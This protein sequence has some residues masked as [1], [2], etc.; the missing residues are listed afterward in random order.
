[1]AS[2]NAE[3]VAT[4]V[5]E[6]IRR[7]GRVNLGEIIHQNGYSKETS[8]KPKL[9]TTTKSYKAIMK[10]LAERMKSEID[11]ITNALANKDLDK[12]EYKTLSDA[13]EKQYKIYQ[14]ATGGVTEN[15]KITIEVSEA[16]AKK[17]ATNT[18]TE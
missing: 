8:L 6:T 9:V 7:G 11:R 2:L 4:I 13:L 17:H 16:I 3:K 15:Q 12:E 10:P 18:I 1:M 5:S 14:I